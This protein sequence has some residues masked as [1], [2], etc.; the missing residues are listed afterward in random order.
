MNGVLRHLRRAALLTAGETLTDAQLLEAFLAC[1]EEA[2]FEVLVKRHGPMVLGVCGRVLGNAHDA[3]D[4]FQATFL[5]LARKAGSV[6]SREALGSWLYGVAYRTATKAR[7]MNA[8][9]RTK[10]K[11]VR[12]RPPAEAPEDSAP[13][14]LL[15]RLD[16]ELNRLP[17]KYRVPVI[18]CDLEGKTRKEAA[19]TLGLPEGTLSWRLAQ[20]KKLLAR[21]LSRHGTALTAGAL[22]PLLSPGSSSAALSPSLVSSTAKAGTA[23]AMGQA[24]TAGAVSAKVLTLTEGVMK[25]MLLTKLKLAT[26]V[27]LF[28]VCVGTGAAYRATATEPRQG[29]DGPQVAR[30]VENELEALR[31][32]IEALRKALQAT[33]DRVRELETQVAALRPRGGGFTGSM[34][35]RDGATPGGPPRMPGPGASIP[36]ATPFAGPS[37]APAS[38]FGGQPGATA[39]TSVGAPAPRVPGAGEKQGTPSVPPPMK[40][41]GVPDQPPSTPSPYLNKGQVGGPPGSHAPAQLLSNIYNSISLEGGSP[42]GG[43]DV[44]AEA[45]AALKKLRQNPNDKQAADALEKALQRL[46]DQEKSRKQ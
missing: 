3:E 12:E 16:A 37:A 26:W 22:A 35:M 31:L 44:L 43:A 10:E 32:E 8:K 2:A 24:L 4:A 25:A 38:P 23:A 30:P 6:R 34:R 5:V 39:E 36:P 17:D 41:G 29:T 14:E 27:V 42:Q 15:A 18:L 20:A 11:Q 46:K 9:R 33:R 28:A 40:Q 45:E 21:R 1:R 13:E 19:R 7:A